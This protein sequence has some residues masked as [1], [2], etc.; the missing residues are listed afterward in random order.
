MNV[1]EGEAFARV[2][3]VLGATEPPARR[4]VEMVLS[5]RARGATFH[6]VAEELRLRRF[7]HPEGRAWTPAAVAEFYVEHVDR[8]WCVAR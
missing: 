1:N 8:L 3:A 6:A 2:Q 4:L 5:R 7:T